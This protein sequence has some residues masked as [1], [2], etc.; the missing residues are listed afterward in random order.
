MTGVQERYYYKGQFTLRE[1]G[2]YVLMAMYGEEVVIKEA[3]VAINNIAD[4]VF[5][6][7]T[8]FAYSLTSRELR[9]D[10]TAERTIRLELY[11]K[12]MNPVVH[13]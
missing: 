8:N 1:P 13:F 5:S 9:S 4:S 11:D 6:K 7:V 10:E 2:D 12:C 3:L